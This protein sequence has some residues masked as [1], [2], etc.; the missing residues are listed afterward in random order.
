[1]CEREVFSF[2]GAG[3]VDRDVKKATKLLEQSADQGLQQAQLFLGL[4]YFDGK[5]I[6]Q[7]PVKATELLKAAAAQKVIMTV[8]R[9][10]MALLMNCL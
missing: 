3:G 7:D 4:C 6:P 2:A 9:I 1:M 10:A 5:H 8:G